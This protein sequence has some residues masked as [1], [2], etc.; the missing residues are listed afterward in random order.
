MEYNKKEGNS[1]RQRSQ[2]VENKWN[3]ETGAET[4]RVV[5]QEY[6]YLYI[7][8]IILTLLSLITY[9]KSLFIAAAGADKRAIFISSIFRLPAGVLYNG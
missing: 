4:K 3:Y 1:D 7:V 9:E 6:W 8:L 5:N 2:E